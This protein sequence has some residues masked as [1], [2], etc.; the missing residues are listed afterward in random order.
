MRYLRKYDFFKEVLTTSTTT[1]ELK[2]DTQEIQSKKSK[3]KKTCFFFFIYTIKLKKNKQYG[4]SN[5]K[6]QETRNLLR[7]V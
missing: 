5:W 3:K 4:N 6:I 2:K 7:R 1:K